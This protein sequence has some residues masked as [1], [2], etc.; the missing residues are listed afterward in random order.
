MFSLIP[1]V[2]WV[3]ISF[4]MLFSGYSHAI[5]ATKITSFSHFLLKIL[6]FSGFML[7]CSILVH[8]SNFNNTLFVWLNSFDVFGCIW[9]KCALCCLQCPFNLLKWSVFLFL[10]S[11]LVIEIK[12]GVTSLIGFR[13]VFDHSSACF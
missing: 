6:I 5:N 2:P 9:L 11:G 4:I 7:S 13:S 10:F 3:L 12:V 1:I 8:T